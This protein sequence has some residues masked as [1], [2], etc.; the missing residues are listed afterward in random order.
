[1]PPAGDTAPFADRYQ[2][3]H[4]VQPVLT[5]IG[6]EF[7]WYRDWLR[8]HLSPVYY[9]VGVPHGNGEPVVVVPGFMGTDL[10]LMEL[11][12]W[13]G[14]IGYRPYYSGLGVNLDCPDASSDL[15]LG[16]VRRAAEETGQ[17]VHLIGHSLGALI[18]RSVTFEHPELVDLLISMAA[19]FNEVAYVHP[20]LIESMSA[21]RRRGGS[22]LTWNLSA[23]CFSGHCTCRFTGNIMRPRRPT[24]R[25][26]A[27]YA[28]GDG[29]VSPESCM[30]EEPEYNVGIATS[31]YGI[32]YNSDAYRTVAESLAEAAG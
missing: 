15:V 28:E 1:M 18:A 20:V 22:H 9:G 19:P 26:R 5:P 21:V 29:L 27:L 10:S 6:N 4:S 7:G 30:E 12:W 8:L 13:L 31:H 14:R 32:V 16:T 25:R 11:F 17:R 3:D 23:T 2:D 24:F